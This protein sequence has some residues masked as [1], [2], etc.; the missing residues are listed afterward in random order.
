MARSAARRRLASV[1][2]GASPASRCAG[3]GG[4]T[5]DSPVAST[6]APGVASGSPARRCLSLATFQ[7]LLGVFRS[8]PAA[9]L[10]DAD[11][12]NFVFRFIDCV[13]NRRRR[14]QRHFVL[15]AASAKKNA[16]SQFCH[17][18]LVWASAALAS[19]AGWVRPAAR[20]FGALKAAL[21]RVCGGETPPRLPAGTP[22]L[23]SISGELGRR[24]RAIFR[25]ASEMDMRT[26]APFAH[27][28]CALLD[29]A[30]K[31]V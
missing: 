23:R 18:E 3:S 13:E 9:L 15:A 21:F 25:V 30:K 12:N 7:K 14:E 4:T 26:L 6:A 11:W 27:D 24:G 2:K 19:I 1:W 22:A 16:H 8:E 17:K 29:S 20:L 10:G 28:L 31:Q 5:T